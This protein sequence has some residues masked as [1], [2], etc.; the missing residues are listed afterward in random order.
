MELLADY[1]LSITYHLGKAIQ[2]ADA[3]TR[4][5]R[6]VERTKEVQELTRTLAGL[7]LCAIT[8]EGQTAGLEALDHAD[9]FWKIRKAQD[10]DKALCK[11]IEIEII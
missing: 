11:H 9:L 4:C 5:M 3:L 10:D 2:V 8:V 6:D 1:N 7:R